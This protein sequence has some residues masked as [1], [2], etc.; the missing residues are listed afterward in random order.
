M[1][2]L[3]LLLTLSFIIVCLYGVGMVIAAKRRER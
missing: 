2:P 3:E 1:S